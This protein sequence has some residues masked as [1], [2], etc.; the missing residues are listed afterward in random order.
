VTKRSV[1]RLR[2]SIDRTTLRTLAAE[3][4]PRP[5]RDAC[6]SRDSDVDS[7]ASV[8]LGDDDLEQEVRADLVYRAFTRID[9]GE[10]PDANTILKIAGALGP[11]V[12]AQ[13]HRQVIEV[14][15]RAGSRTAVDFASTPRS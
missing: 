12:I 9:A 6:G 15:K 4:P 11:D 2:R 3:S 10:V 13:L 1:W 8:R 14:A 7:E 5:P